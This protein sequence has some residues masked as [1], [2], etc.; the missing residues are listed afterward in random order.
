MMVVKKAIKMAVG[1]MEVERYRWIAGL[2]ISIAL[3]GFGTA[4]AFRTTDAHI[5]NVVKSNFTDISDGKGMYARE[6][7]KRITALEEKLSAI[8]RKLKENGD[9][10]TRI[11]ANLEQL[12]SRCTDE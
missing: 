7:R 5:L 1:N 6:G 10:L 3:T 8:D 2:V 12:L 11:E 9:R 4:Y